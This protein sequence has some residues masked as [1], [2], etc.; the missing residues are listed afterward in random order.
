[1]RSRGTSPVGNMQ[2][3]LDDISRSLL[4][5]DEIRAE[6]SNN[7]ICPGRQLDILTP[8][9][10]PNKEHIAAGVEASKAL[11]ASKPKLPL[12]R[13]GKRKQQITFF[14]VTNLCRQSLPSLHE[15]ASSSRPSLSAAE[16]NAMSPSERIRFKGILTLPSS[17]RHEQHPSASQAEQA[18]SNRLASKDNRRRSNDKHKKS[19]E[20]Q[21]RK[22]A[23]TTTVVKQNK[24]QASNDVDTAMA[25]V[26]TENEGQD[27]SNQQAA[28]KEKKLKHNK[29]VEKQ[30]SQ[31]HAPP[32]S[33]SY[34]QEHQQIDNDIGNYDPID[35]ANQ[36][37]QVQQAEDNNPVPHTPSAQRDAPDVPDDNMRNVNTPSPAPRSASH[38][39]RSVSRKYYGSEFPNLRPEVGVKLQ[40][41]TNLDYSSTAHFATKGSVGS[42]ARTY[43][44]GTQQAA[45]AAQASG[46]LTSQPCA[47]C[48][49]GHGTFNE[50]RLNPVWSLNGTCVSCGYWGHG[51]DCSF[52]D[53]SASETPAKTLTQCSKHLEKLIVSIKEEAQA[54][55]TT[56]RSLENHLSHSCFF[57]NFSN[58][59][60]DEASFVDDCKK[61]IEYYK[62]IEYLHSDIESKEQDLAAA[63]EAN[64]LARQVLLTPCFSGTQKEQCD[65]TRANREQE[66]SDDSLQHKRPAPS[67]KCTPVSINIDPSSIADDN[68]ENNASNENEDDHV[69]NST[70]DDGDSDND[71]DDSNADSNDDDSTSESSQHE[72]VNINRRDSDNIFG[73]N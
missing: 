14:A 33:M 22:A 67:N 58:A 37:Q 19:I 29:T 5:E 23:S 56:L 51:N 41:G 34:T 32:S 71:I 3:M 59:R 35:V 6:Q 36:E 61:I 25:I 47:K 1:M 73:N 40:S 38:N 50:C 63:I 55:H 68:N 9:H 11:L 39:L 17:L 15:Q 69:S 54:M 46:T 72:S 10:H 44:S 49:Q 2:D 7:S 26:I 20:K 31:R 48:A 70:S 18:R 28:K 21:A 4:E 57:F 60:A 62:L 30:K 52:I 65:Q 42:I 13:K 24:N 53:D 64:K 45:I 16:V 8:G 43:P 12:G 66:L 27:S